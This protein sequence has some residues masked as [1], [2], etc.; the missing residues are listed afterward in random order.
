M[1]LILVNNIIRSRI[2]QLYW[3]IQPQH[4]LPALP[5]SYPRIR[6]TSEILENQILYNGTNTF[7]T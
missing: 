3:N 4:N 7:D 6:I 2:R 5:W 1:K